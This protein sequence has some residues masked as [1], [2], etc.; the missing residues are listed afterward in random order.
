M[1]KTSQQFNALM[2]EV[3]TG[4]ESAAEE[5]FR[6]YEPYLLNVIRRRLNK[7]IRSKFDSLDIAQDV[8]K[9]FFEDIRL[10]RGF[11]TAEDLV[12]FLARLARNKV[13]DANRKRLDT[14]KRDARREES[15]DKLHRRDRDRLTDAAQRTP[16]QIMMSQEE[17][18]EYLRKQPLLY[19]RILTLAREGKLQDQ[20]AE[21]LRISVKTVQRVIGRAMTRP[22]S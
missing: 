12:A 6:D 17:W 15:L 19:R 5:L 9:S 20:I 22:N 16:S 8:W 10:E 11:D 7:S 2:Q 4:S 3:L 14:G 21:E 18:K 13:V 1:V